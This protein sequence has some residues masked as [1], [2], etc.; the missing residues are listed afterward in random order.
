M[1]WSWLWW[2]AAAAV[3]AAATA[4]LCSNVRVRIRYFREGHNDE[5]DAAVTALFGLVRLRYK[6]P[7]IELK[8]WL[9]GIRLKVAQDQGE[10]VT[11][12]PEFDFAREEI[13]RFFRRAKLLIE[14]MNDFRKFFAGTLQHVHVLELRWETRFGLGGAA[15]TGVT[16]GAVWALKNAVL[17]VASRWMSFE[18]RPQVRVSPV[19]AE[20]LF[21]TDAMVRSRIRVIRLIMIG[22]ML[23]FRVAR[24]KGGWLVWLRVLLGRR[25]TERATTQ[26]RPA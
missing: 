13:E 23:L 25:A 18:R 4:V 22:T 6:V 12:L 2:L 5:V 11:P 15:E 3:A 16:S 8:P 17:G 26:R 20:T 14:H 9:S 24:R 10:S 21:R 19:F 1:S 7:T